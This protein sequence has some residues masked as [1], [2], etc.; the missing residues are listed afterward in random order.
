MISSSAYT[1]QRRRK[2][3]GPPEGI[4][5]GASDGVK[6]SEVGWMATVTKGAEGGSG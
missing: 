2:R 5:Q 6:L 1:A 3:G 4:A